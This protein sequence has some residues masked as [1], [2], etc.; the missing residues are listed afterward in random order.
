MKVYFIRHGQTK[1]NREGRYVGRTDEPLLAE[2]KKNF[3]KKSDF[4]SRP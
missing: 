4:E 2:T 1:G 3:L